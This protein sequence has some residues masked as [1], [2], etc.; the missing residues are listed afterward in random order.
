MRFHLVHI[1]IPRGHGL[2]GYREVIDSVQWGL[3]QLGHSV[4]Y[5]VNQVNSDA[6]NIV[7]GMQVL[8]EEQQANFPADSIVYN[9]EQLRGGTPRHE[10]RAA[11]QRF[12]IWDYASSN[13]EPWARLG[14]P[15]QPVHV[16]VAYAP[17]LERIGA[18]AEQDIDVLIYGMP[19]EL[20]MAAFYALT[21]L[22]L[23][24]VFVCGLYG[25]ARDDLIARSKLVLNVALYGQRR[26]FEI[27]RVSYLWAN[28]K[29]VIANIDPD[30]A[31][32]D[33]VLD[34]LAPVNRETLQATAEALIRD[35]RARAEIA[36]RGYAFFR[37]R[38]IR[39]I[40]EAALEA[41][42]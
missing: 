40:L 26:I 11:G 34:A 13:M 21:Q 19:N 18:T 12:L 29:T 28:R 24:V 1:Q 37:K 35:A 42:G 25:A 2:L 20:R 9:F 16:P 31:M 15:R 41:M 27:V 6:R 33:G 17:V 8:S 7:F 14:L 22:G 4:S 36:E 5:G 3:T 30:T 32:D 10:L 38:D 23:T 39:P